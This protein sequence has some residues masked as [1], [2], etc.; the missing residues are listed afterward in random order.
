MH[1][2]DDD[3]NDDDDDGTCMLISAPHFCSDPVVIATEDSGHSV[4][5]TG[6]HFPINMMYRSILH[7]DLLY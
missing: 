5:L 1:D 6:G 3:G 4:S 7:I 2:G